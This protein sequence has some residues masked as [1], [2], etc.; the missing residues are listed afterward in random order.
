M[1]G[2]FEGVAHK[3]LLDEGRNDRVKEMKD[4]GEATFSFGAF[5]FLS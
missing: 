1:P 4:S 3:Y 2:T 5:S